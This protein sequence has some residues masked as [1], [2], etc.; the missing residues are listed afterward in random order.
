MRNSI[1]LQVILAVIGVALLIAGLLYV[2]TDPVL[3]WI[4]AIGGLLIVVGAVM[5]IL[6]L[7]RTTK[8]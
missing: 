1:L 7:R 3:G 5:A 4:G 2:S 6:K 8:A